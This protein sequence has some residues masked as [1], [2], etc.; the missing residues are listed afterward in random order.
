MVLALELAKEYYHI[1][2]VVVVH[3]R[4]PEWIPDK[5]NTDQMFVIE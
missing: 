3:T 2:D 1:Q 5:F 4:G